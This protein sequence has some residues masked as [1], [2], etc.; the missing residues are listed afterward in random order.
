[1]S[2]GPTQQQVSPNISGQTPAASPLDYTCRSKQWPAQVQ[3]ITS[4]FTAI[5]SVVSA[6]AL[7]L[8][9]AIE[10]ITQPKENTNL[11]NREEIYMTMKSESESESESEI[12]ERESDV[13][14]K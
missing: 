4:V 1:M 2:E 3:A 12:G 11:D 13:K 14:R 9:L 7:L 8:M 10:Y 6:I 5:G